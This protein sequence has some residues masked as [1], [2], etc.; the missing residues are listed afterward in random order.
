MNNYWRKKNEII[1]SISIS[2]LKTIKEIN[3]KL[4]FGTFVLFM[5]KIDF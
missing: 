5:I 2:K 4:H 3:N 1:K